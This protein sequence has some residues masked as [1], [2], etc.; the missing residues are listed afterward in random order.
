MNPPLIHPALLAKLT[1]LLKFG[2]LSHDGKNYVY[3]PLPELT[4]AFGLK[5][6]QEWACKNL[7]DLI[8][9]TFKLLLKHEEDSKVEVN[10]QPQLFK[11]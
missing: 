9:Q 8:L 10:N 11:N 4:K 2:S 3:R 1:A 5:E 7:H 6:S